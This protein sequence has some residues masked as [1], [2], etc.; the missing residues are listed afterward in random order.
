MSSVA[1]CSPRDLTTTFSVT[2]F[3][4]ATAWSVI[5]AR[6]FWYF[7]RSC[8]QEDFSS[9]RAAWST[10]GSCELTG[11]AKPH[12]P[13]KKKHLT[14]LS[15]ASP[16]PQFAYL[17]N[18]PAGAGGLVL[19]R[20]WDIKA[21]LAARSNAHPSICVGPSRTP[22]TPRARERPITLAATSHG[23]ATPQRVRGTATTV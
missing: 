4:L 12:I 21:N 9:V 22:I 15:N 14:Q 23:R 18:R 7:S 8:F 5:S 20:L 6:K 17:A 10:S 19:K 13:N 1:C 3:P 11:R 2:C 16:L